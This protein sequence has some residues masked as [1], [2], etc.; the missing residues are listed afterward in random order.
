MM[1]LGERLRSWF[2]IL[3]RSWPTRLGA[4][5]AIAGLIAL[6]VAIKVVYYPGLPAP[7]KVYDIV[8]TNK[9][10][11]EEERQ[12]FYHSSQGS[13]VMPN[14]W[15]LALE[16]PN[17]DELFI[18]NDYMSK[19]RFL[20][21]PNSLHNPN[22]LP[23]GFA[24]DDP[25]P[26]TGVENLGLSCA[27]CH[28]A[29]IT[30][31]GMG[32]RVDGA[33]GVF[34][35]DLFLEQLILAVGVTEAPQIFQRFFD[36]GKFDRFAHR[37]LGKKYSRDAADKL[38]AEVKVWLREK[39]TLKAQEIQSD[40]VHRRKATTSGF[41]RLDALGTGG[42]TVYRKLNPKNLSVLNAPVK[43]FPLWYASEYDWVQSNGSIRQPLARN[44]IEALA[45]NAYVALPGKNEAG[46]YISSA[47]LR[48]MWEMENAAAKLAAPAWQESILGRIDLAK[49]ERGKALYGQYCSN[50]HSPKIEPAPLCGDEIAIRNKKR[51]FILRLFNYETIGTDE[52]DAT[53]FAARTLDASALGLGP[54]TSG[55]TIIAM[56]VGGVLRKG[57]QDP[58]LGLTEAKMDD[59][60]GY[61]AD[62]WRAPR[63]YPA[64]PLDGAWAAAPYLHNA[65]VPNMYQLL[66]PGEQ[67]DKVFYT[68][69]TEYDPVHL[70]Y[71][72]ARFPGAFRLDT[73]QQGN[74]N[75]GHEF[76]NAP[77]GSRGVIGP[78]L[79]DTQR[80]EL[81]EYMKVISEFPDARKAAASQP[82]SSWPRGCWT[83]ES[84][85]SAGGC[86]AVPLSAKPGTIPQ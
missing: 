29:V 65:T 32:I 44:I 69:S 79:N 6:A 37:V 23:I 13:E 7:V 17:S 57:L 24:K 53:N 21:D 77:A 1:Q 83:D 42:N 80:Y 9:V 54:N 26:V 25:D 41:G 33:P 38:H 86:K 63:A 45:V 15:F 11:T 58:K 62:C 78:E 34:N 47:R 66:L 46:R 18:S 61:R 73:G 14:D 12:M 2:R 81:I 39:V 52:N 72:T 59:W 5:A 75:R 82:Y 49:A 31:K 40:A 19:F 28:T 10:W 4:F 76:R 67:R 30:Y 27:L 71:E 55:P 60:V 50:C 8:N 16:Q 64:R 20:P 70:G 22:L 68:G 35:F 74:S 48:Q 36:P 51:Y 84:Y 85:G 56:A 3:N 43:A